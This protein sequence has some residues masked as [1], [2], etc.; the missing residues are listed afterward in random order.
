MP[1]RT[2]ERTRVTSS[3]RF[4]DFV[5]CGDHDDRDVAGGRIALE[6]A[7]HLEAAHARHHD[8]EQ[9]DVGPLRGDRTHGLNPVA[10]GPDLAAQVLEIGLEELKILVI[11]VHDE[12]GCPRRVQRGGLQVGVGRAG[13]LW[14]VGHSNLDCPDDEVRTQPGTEG[15]RRKTQQKP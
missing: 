15:F 9:D 11:V 1:S 13:G 14:D 3:S 4:V 12:D 5:E 10:G 8:I 6:L 2:S 7:A